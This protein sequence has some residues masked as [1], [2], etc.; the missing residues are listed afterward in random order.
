M[1]QEFK[2]SLPLLA[3][4][5]R[6]QD[7]KIHMPFSAEY[8]GF[9]G[10]L[11]STQTKPPASRWNFGLNEFNPSIRGKNGH[12]VGFDRLGDAG[13]GT[14][15]LA[16]DCVEEKHGLAKAL[17]P[18]R[19]YFDYLTKNQRRYNYSVFL[20]VCITQRWTS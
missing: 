11:T 3:G 18:I 20:N 17:A 9:S 8:G 2:E 15:N 7:G 10:G 13:L 19:P 6:T 16:V 1:R 12:M 14:V 4:V 5:V